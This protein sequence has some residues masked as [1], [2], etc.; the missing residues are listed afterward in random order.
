MRGARVGIAVAVA[1]LGAVAAVSAATGGQ[2]APGFVEPKV[3]RSHNGV[4]K[5]DWQAE[6]GP[7]IIAGR[8]VQDTQTYTGTYPGP[9]LQVQ[10][11]DR[12]ELALTSH[13]NEP[14][15][16]HF[17]GFR[18][19]PAGISDNVLRHMMP[20]STNRVVV[21]IP[22]DHERGLYWYHAHPH[23]F[24]EN[25][26]YQ[27]LAGLI[28]VGDVLEPYPELR[29]LTQRVLAI[30]SVEFSRRG[31]LVDAASASAERATTLVNGQLQPTLKMRPGELQLWRL[32][33]ISSDTWYRVALDGHTLYV[34]AED[35]NT[36]PRLK[37][38]KV[39]LMPPGKRFEFLVRAGKA[40]TYTL[41]TLGDDEGFENFPARKLATL[42][43]AGSE[44]TPRALPASLAPV[45]DL[46]FEP[47]A[48]R[49][50]WVWRIV[51]KP[52]LAFEIN[53]KVFD[54]HRVDAKVKLGT[55]EEWVLKNVSGEDHPFHIHTNDFQV[56][57]IAGK[58]VPFHGYQDIVRIPRHS[59]A[60]IRLKARAFTGRAVFHCHILFHEDHG[61]M[62]V[63]EW[64]K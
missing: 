27:G 4:L 26:V 21:Q 56:I 3:L 23:S 51:T 57:E 35:G 18:V 49:R 44:V 63:V 50:T 41:R 16:I 60:T 64:V 37:P 28:S 52:K 7:A 25:Q 38:A 15:N 2:A 62:A 42:R 47:I 10:P 22:K 40:G 59:T 12:I 55:V 17:H 33:N 20:G 58:P 53:G 1:A 46:R 24:T 45:G 19:S 34:L 39:L 9:T 29:G 13:L 31:T 61:M 54:P 6:I 36:S 8:P 14:T 30:S 48:R 43:V 32:A 5:L 11:G